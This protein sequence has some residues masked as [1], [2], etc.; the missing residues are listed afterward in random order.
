[1]RNEIVRVGA[2]EHKYLERT[3]SL[4]SLNQR[5]EI[6]DQFRSKKIHRLAMSM[7]HI[8]SRQVSAAREDPVSE[9]TCVI[10]G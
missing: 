5:D 9:F 6:A 2:R 1:M 4:G 10:G 3:V 8:D 7:C